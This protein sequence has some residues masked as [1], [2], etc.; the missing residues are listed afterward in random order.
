MY[1]D[2]FVQVRRYKLVTMV[3]NDITNL[4]TMVTCGT[5]RLVTMVTND[6]TNFL[7]DIINIAFLHQL[8]KITVE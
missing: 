3:T 8:Q 7:I 5:T 1:N 6:T 4:V 2:C